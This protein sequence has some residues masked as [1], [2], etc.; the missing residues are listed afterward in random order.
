MVGNVHTAKQEL[1]HFV[2]MGQTISFKAIDC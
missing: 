1:D 2:E